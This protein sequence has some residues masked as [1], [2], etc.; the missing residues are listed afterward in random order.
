MTSPDLKIK[1]LEFIQQVITRMNS[2]SFMIK[3]WTVT[4]TSAL[5]A[6]AA[7]NAN[8]KFIMISFLVIPMFFFLDGYYLS[9]ERKFRKLYEHVCS[10]DAKTINFAMDPTPYCGYKEKWV[11]AT[12]SRTIYPFY[13]GLIGLV[14]FIKHFLI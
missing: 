2:N 5:F 1:H 8:Q 9:Q 13:V 7:N 6:L 4:L 14:L 11:A 10:Q 12:T 3:G